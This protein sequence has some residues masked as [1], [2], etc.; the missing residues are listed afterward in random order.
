M[1]FVLHMV[2]GKGLNFTQLEEKQ[3]QGMTLNGIPMIR[4]EN[5]R[6]DTFRL[7]GALIKYTS[8]S[9]D[10]TEGQLILKDKLLKKLLISGGSCR[11][12]TG[13]RTRQYF[14]GPTESHHLD[15]LQ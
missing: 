4:Q 3:Y 6:G 15:L 10:S 13:P 12:I 14:R 9:L 1:C 11:N 8:L 7:R 5:G 2:S